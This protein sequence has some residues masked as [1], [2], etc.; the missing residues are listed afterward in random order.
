MDTKDPEIRQQGAAG[1]REHVTLTIPQ[2][3]E[4]MKSHESGES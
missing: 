1:K 2:K 3:L 4:I